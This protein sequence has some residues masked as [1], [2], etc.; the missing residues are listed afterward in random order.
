MATLETV[1]IHNFK[2]NADMDSKFIINKRDFD[3][4]KHEIFGERKATQK[5]AASKTRSQSQAKS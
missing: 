1:E 4:E 5:P 2:D 3:P